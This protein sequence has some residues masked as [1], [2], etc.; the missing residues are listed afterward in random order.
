MSK[1]TIKDRVQ[2]I[3]EQCSEIEHAAEHGDIDAVAFAANEIELCAEKIYR[4]AKP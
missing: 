3:R 4:S 1:E 2:I